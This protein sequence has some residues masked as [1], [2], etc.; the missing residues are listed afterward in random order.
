MA[1]QLIS[2]GKLSVLYEEG[3]IRYLKVQDIEVVRMLYFA[4]RDQ[5]WET[6]PLK[7]RNEKIKEM[8]KSK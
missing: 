1:G 3:F 4:L 5:Q 8:R 6:V 2:I 7:I